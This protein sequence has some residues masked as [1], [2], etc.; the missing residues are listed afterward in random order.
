VILSGRSAWALS[1]LAPL[2]VACGRQ[3]H[4]FEAGTDDRLSVVCTT[5]STRVSLMSEFLVTVHCRVRGDETVKFDPALPGDTVGTVVRLPDRE[6]D[7]GRWLR[8]ELRLRPTRVDPEFAI[9]PFAAAIE[10]DDPVTA[11]S[12]ELRI[13]VGSVLEAGES[14]SDGGFGPGLEDPG[15]LLLPP[16]QWIRFWAAVALLLGLGVGLFLFLRRRRAGVPLVPPIVELPPHVVALEALRR[17][18][19]EPR[20]TPSQVEAFYRM[21]AQALRV[22]LERRFGLRAPEQTSEEFLQEVERG[23][24]LSASQ[25]IELRPFLQQCDLVKFAAHLPPDREHL[26]TLAMA[27]RFVEATR[28]DRPD[29]RLQEAAAR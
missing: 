26:E 17:L 16:G 28:V 5:S 24:P 18:R 6:I 29:V 8:A 14:E 21:V 15:P 12:E 27:E 2:V 3:Q 1:V 22:Y 13:E 10:G 20:A 4:P 11:S 25:C 9:G 23:G 19:A 7:G